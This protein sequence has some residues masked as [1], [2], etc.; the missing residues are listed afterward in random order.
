[1]TTLSDIR[2]RI[3]E[4]ADKVN[5]QFV[6]NA[7]L[8]SLINGSYAELWDLIIQSCEDYFTTTT[9]FTLTSSDSGVYALPAAF[10]KLRG[11][12]YSIGGSYVTVPSYDW[13]ARN[14]A[15]D[16]VNIQTGLDVSYRIMGTNL[17]IEPRD[18][19]TGGYQLWYIPA[20]TALSADADVINA[21][22]T[23]QNWEEYIVL[24]VA[25]KILDKEESN[26]DHLVQAKEILRRRINEFA[27]NRDLDQPMRVSTSRNRRRRYW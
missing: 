27:A 14:D 16:I 9:T 4:R 7:E 17:K 22:L 3:R 15:V 25:K 11:L 19:A 2:T 20:Y 10:Y 21:Q 13:N 18:N 23:K 6:T 24:D 26:S 8:L 12:D 5:S 1:M